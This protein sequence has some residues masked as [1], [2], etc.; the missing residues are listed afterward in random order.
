M[1]SCLPRK[2]SREGGRLFTSVS[3]CDWVDSADLYRGKILPLRARVEVRN[4]WI[5]KD[6]CHTFELD[7]KKSVPE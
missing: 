3:S 2:L 4:R 1:P 6:T 7:A 5:R